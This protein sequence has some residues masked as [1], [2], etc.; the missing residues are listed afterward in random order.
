MDNIN[1]VLYTIIAVYK[2]YTNTIKDI[3]HFIN[4]FLSI[5][6]EKLK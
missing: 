4:I 6:K 2:I 3:A 5:L 1:D